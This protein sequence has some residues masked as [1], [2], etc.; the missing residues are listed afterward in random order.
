MRTAIQA[1]ATTPVLSYSLADTSEPPCD[2][3]M[4]MCLQGALEWLQWAS[5]TAL[6][7]ISQHS[8]PSRE[9][10]SGALGALPLDSVTEDPLR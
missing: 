10:P 3:A 6:A 4:T 1:P 9:P 2:I 7:P 5:P 8:M